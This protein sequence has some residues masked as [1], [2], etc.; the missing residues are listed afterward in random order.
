MV[1]VLLIEGN[2]KYSKYKRIYIDGYMHIAIILEINEVNNNCYCI[3]TI[4]PFLEP[5]R[6]PYMIFSL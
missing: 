2:E 6:L 1:V 4:N 3:T 5:F